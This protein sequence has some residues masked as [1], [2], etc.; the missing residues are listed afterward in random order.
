MMDEHQPLNPDR[1]QVARPPLSAALTAIPRIFYAPTSVFHDIRAGL[2]WWP[3]LIV[4]VL[5]MVGVGL[6]QLP[7]TLEAVDA[8]IASGEIDTSRGDSEALSGQMRTFTTIGSIAGPAIGV[9]LVLVVVSALFWL[10]LLITFGAARYGRMFTLV[11]YTSFIG[12]SYQL[13]NAVY[14][15]MTHPETTGPKDLETY[16]L[17]F[18]LNAFLEN[19]KSFLGGFLGSF[20]IFGIWG[21]WLLV[22]GAALLLAR[23][24]SAVLWPILV[25]AILLALVA[26]FF[27]GLGA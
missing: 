1:E 8:G 10:A 9:P 5:I 26:G 20:D 25:V 3:G 6:I 15:R 16:S 12:I 22:A 24:K 4:L 18:G 27:A 23:R 21:L 2:A 13:I 7:V 17:K 11:I 14:L 19:P